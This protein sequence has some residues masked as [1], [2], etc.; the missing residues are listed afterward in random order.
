MSVTAGS[1]QRI[2]RIQETCCFTMFVSYPY[3]IYGAIYEI[4]NYEPLNIKKLQGVN[5]IRLTK[6]CGGSSREGIAKQIM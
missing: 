3:S 2:K 5:Q 1:R 4:L 6:P